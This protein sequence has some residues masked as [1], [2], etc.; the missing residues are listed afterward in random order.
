MPHFN[1]VLGTEHEDDHSENS[2]DI[3]LFLEPGS[4]IDSTF[5]D[6][7]AALASSIFTSITFL[8]LSF[9]YLVLRASEVEGLKKF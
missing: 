5:G 4:A 7:L 3:N 2:F 1:I 8:I 9:D 6:V